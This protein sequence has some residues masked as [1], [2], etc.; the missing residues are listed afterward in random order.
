MKIIQVDPTQ[1]YTDAIKEAIAVLES[2]GVILHPTDTLYGLAANALHV[3][4]VEKVFKIKQRSFS[5]P[6]PIIA[7][8]MKWVKE[9]AEI[10]PRQEFMLEKIWPGVVTAV[11]PKNKVIPDVV[12]SGHPNVAIRIPDYK[13]ID[14]LLGKYGY[15]LTMTSANISGEEPTQRIDDIIESLSHGLAMPDLVIDVGTLPPSEPSTLIDFTGAQPKILRVGA[16]KP[17]QLMELLEI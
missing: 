17:Q 14:V 8:N 9:L 15:P 16:A 7:R 2:G 4:A 13:M 12:T 10:T 3:R 5:K 1:D 6:L 11:L